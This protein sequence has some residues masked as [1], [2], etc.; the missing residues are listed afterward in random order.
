MTRYQYNVYKAVKDFIAKHN[1]SPSVR[2]LSEITGKS[3]IGTIQSH[4]KNLKKLGYIDYQEGK[5]RTI[6]IIKDFVC[7]YE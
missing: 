7:Y 1:Y 6:R 2:E 4:L 5:S 3:S